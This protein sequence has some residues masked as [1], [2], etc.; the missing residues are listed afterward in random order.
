MRNNCGNSSGDGGGNTKLYH[1]GCCHND[2]EFTEDYLSPMMRAMNE[3]FEG[4]SKKKKA[5][6][7]EVLTKKDIIKQYERAKKEEKQFENEEYD[8]G[9]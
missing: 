2:K 7:D 9:K 3:T 4:T 6:T 5:K 8:V 1:K